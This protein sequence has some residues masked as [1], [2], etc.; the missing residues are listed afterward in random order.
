MR[1]SFYSIDLIEW[2]DL[3]VGIFLVRVYYVSTK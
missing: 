2:S 3:I 1:V